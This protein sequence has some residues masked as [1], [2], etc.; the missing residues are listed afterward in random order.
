MIVNPN[1]RRQ[2]AS[3]DFSQIPKHTLTG[4]AAQDLLVQVQAD[5]DKF[6][7]YDQNGS[8]R[9]PAAG[10]LDVYRSPARYQAE[11]YNNSLYVSESIY[12]S[13]DPN[14]VPVY[15]RMRESEQNDN[16]VIRYEANQD[17]SGITLRRYDITSQ[18]ATV[19][20]W[21]SVDPV[22]ANSRRSCP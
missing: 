22:V 15:L 11:V 13:A 16:R 20:E 9:D 3:V 1:L 14:G 6:V 10:R 8:D 12:P 18:T 17:A 4:Q 19:Q 5:W 7:A 2:F 21:L